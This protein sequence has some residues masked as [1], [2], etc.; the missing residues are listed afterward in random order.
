M[1][2][3]RSGSISFPDLNS[4]FTWGRDYEYQLASQLIRVTNNNTNDHSG[5]TSVPD[6][7]DVPDVPVYRMAPSADPVHLYVILKRHPEE[8]LYMNF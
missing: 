2:Y 3:F 7:P 6:V 8:G 5:C 4:D 1:G